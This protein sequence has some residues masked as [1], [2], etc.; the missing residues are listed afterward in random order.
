VRR[1]A[2]ETEAPN[3]TVSSPVVSPPLCFRRWPVPLGELASSVD[4]LCRDGRPFPLRELVIESSPFHSS[5]P[6]TEISN[7]KKRK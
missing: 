2:R 1:G 5:P 7:L 3:K 6:A 4:A